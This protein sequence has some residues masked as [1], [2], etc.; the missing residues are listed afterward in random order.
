MTTADNT[1]K[2]SQKAHAFQKRRVQVGEKHDNRDDLTPGEAGN[3]LLC[4]FL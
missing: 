4:E 3:S 2:R 1:E